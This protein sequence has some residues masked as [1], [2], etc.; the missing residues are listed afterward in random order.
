MAYEEVYLME[1]GH[2]I[3]PEWWKLKWRPLRK[4]NFNI[5][6]LK[7]YQ[8]YQFGFHVWRHDKHGWHL[9]FKR[10]DF[11]IHFGY[12]FLFWIKWDYCCHKDGPSD[13]AERRPLKI[14]MNP[15]ARTKTNE[16]KE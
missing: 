12:Q 3:A 8:L 14:P 7:P 15:D 5:A 4:K 10:F 6:I 13:V 9:S 11:A 16:V 2:E 1:P